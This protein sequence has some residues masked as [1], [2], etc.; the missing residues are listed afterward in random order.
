MRLL[1]ILLL[2]FSLPS[3]TTAQL[4]GDTEEG[5][6]SYYS[7][8]YEGAETPYGEIYD[9]TKMVAAHKLFPYNSTVRVKNIENGNTAIVRIIDKGPFIRGRIIELSEAAAAKLGML[10]K[11]TAQVEVTLL[12]TPDQPSRTSAVVTEEPVVIPPTDPE[13]VVS[14]PRPR[15]EIN[16]PSAEPESQSSRRTAP[17]TVTPEPTPI[18][19]ERTPEITVPTPTVTAT[20]TREAVKR[21]GE[22]SKDM[23]RDQSTFAPGV[24]KI[25]L[26]APPA[27]NFGVQVGSFRE[28]ERAIDKVAQLQKKWFDNILI[29]KVPAAEGHIYK[30]IL[31][32]FDDQASAKNY[33]SDLKS[34]YKMDGFTVVLSR[35]P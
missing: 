23:I 4:V 28:I 12:S 31:G 16:T 27:G 21:T 5:L 3:I 33:A 29:E 1:L 22:N 34:R 17:V 7:S 6:A 10:G 24:Y 9:K 20:S 11:P 35:R 13:P 30:V 25:E 19:A 15:E 26:L 32:P 8:E 18:P 2:T 14:T